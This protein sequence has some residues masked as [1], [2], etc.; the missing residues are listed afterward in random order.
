[1]QKSRSAE[2]QKF[3]NKKQGKWL[4]FIVVSVCLAISAFYELIEWW[5]ASATGTAAEAF[6]GIQGYV[7]DT[8]SD[9]AFALFGAVTALLLL[10]KCHDSQLQKL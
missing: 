5:G 2:V 4:S 9:M 3:R 10:G 8:Q 1:V 7:W 6:L